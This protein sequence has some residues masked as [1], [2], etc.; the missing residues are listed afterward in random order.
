MAK[1]PEKQLGYAKEYLKNFDEIKLRVPK[2]EKTNIKAH[3]DSII[4]GFGLP[5]IIYSGKSPAGPQSTYCCKMIL[6]PP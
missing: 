3:A 5:L 6:I 4:K 2:G 1:T